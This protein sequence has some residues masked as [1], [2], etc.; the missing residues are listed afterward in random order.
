MHCLVLTAGIDVL[1]PIQLEKKLLCCCGGTTHVSLFD[2]EVS[3][4]TALIT[5]L[6]VDA[7]MCDV[8]S[9]LLG[10]PRSLM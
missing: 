9:P 5:N 1:S 10:G 3:C 7:G 2:L 8:L 4:V 6:L